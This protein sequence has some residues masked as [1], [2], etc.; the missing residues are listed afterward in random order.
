[1]LLGVKAKVDGQAVD[2]VDVFVG[3]SSGPHAIQGIRILEGVP[4]DTLP[5]TL[6]GLIRHLEPDKVRRQ[7]RAISESTPAPKHETAA[8][9]V[10]LVPH[11]DELTGPHG[12]E[13]GGRTCPTSSPMRSS[14]RSSRP[15]RRRA[16]SP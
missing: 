16:G 4:C 7:L 2:A 13:N 8:K 1:G 14:N 15:A 3:G 12:T 9:P 11:A 5:E 6:E 10:Q